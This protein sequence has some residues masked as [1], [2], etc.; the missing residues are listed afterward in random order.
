MFMQQVMCLI[1]TKICIHAKKNTLVEL[2]SK[3]F[4]SVSSLVVIDFC[5]NNNQPYTSNE[6]IVKILSRHVSFVLLFC[7]PYFGV[8]VPTY[9][10]KCQG[11]A[12]VRGIF[13]WLQ[14]T[15]S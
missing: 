12:L 11:D 10:R 3:F 13:G 5:L 9:N 4:C 1:S 8:L 14:Y 2:D 7:S 15:A 6:T